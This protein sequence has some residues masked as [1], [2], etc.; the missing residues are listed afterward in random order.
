M[1]SWYWPHFRQLHFSYFFIGTNNWYVH[2]TGYSMEAIILRGYIHRSMDWPNRQPTKISAIGIN[3]ISHFGHS[4]S[5]G[6][7]PWRQISFCML[8]GDSKIQQEKTASW[9]PIFNNDRTVTMN[10]K[11]FAR[12]SSLMLFGNPMVGSVRSFGLDFPLEAPMMIP[13]KAC[14]RYVR[15]WLLAATLYN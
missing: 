7:Y 13:T 4:L 2:G 8:P 10:W 12:N 11:I 5:F 9:M 15:M 6:L 3:C 14:T 1:K